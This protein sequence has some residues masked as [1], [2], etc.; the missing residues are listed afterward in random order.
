ME[1]ILDVDRGDVVGH[2]HDFVGM[3]F[4]AVFAL[5]RF[6]R[7][8]PA[9]QQARDEGARAGKGVENVDVL[10]GERAAELPLQDVSHRADDEV[11]HLDGSVDY[12]QLVDRAWRG[13][14]EEFV[15]Q[16]DDDA[17]ASLG[18]RNVAYGSAD[19]V[20]ELLQLLVFLLGFGLVVEQ[21]E[22]LLHGARNGVTGRKLVVLEKGLEHG[23]RNDMLR[24][25]LYGILLRE[26]GV[27]VAVQA[28]HELVEGAAVSAVVGNE[29]LDALDVLFGN[30]CNVLGPQFP[31]AFGADPGHQLGIEDVLQVVEAQGQL[32][33][34]LLGGTQAA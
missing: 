15:V 10:V 2:Q 1:D 33:G 20:V 17:L 8:Q 32:L 24:E 23:A 18:I 21:V 22:H 34:Q 4:P 16:L 13:H 3:Y 26:A 25:H 29:G 6:A 27:D 31:V 7:N 12:A 9:L 11:D 14:L 28:A 19:I 5:Q 30:L